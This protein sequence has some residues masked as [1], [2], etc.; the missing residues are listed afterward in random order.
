MS[1]V[2]NTNLKTDDI[3]VGLDSCESDQRESADKLN[4]SFPVIECAKGKKCQERWLLRESVESFLIQERQ[5]MPKLSRNINHL[6]RNFADSSAP[7]PKISNRM[8]EQERALQ[9]NLSKIG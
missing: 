1:D 6:I 7:H 8:Q 4:T 3:T 5:L 2:L 9:F